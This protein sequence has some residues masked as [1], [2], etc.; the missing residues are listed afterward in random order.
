M[1]RRLRLGAGGDH[2]PDRDALVRM[3][4]R[5]ERD[6]LN[7]SRAE[8]YEL[9]YATAF[10]LPPEEL[11]ASAAPAAGRTEREPRPATE[12]QVPDVIT[13]IADALHVGPADYPGRD[14][15]QLE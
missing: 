1:A 3:I 8:R 15:A 14:R 5:W 6:G 7:T 11:H 10:G 13:A 12:A 9:L 2:L 4:R